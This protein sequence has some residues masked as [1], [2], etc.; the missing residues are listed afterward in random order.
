MVH[1]S[2]AFVPHRESAEAMK[3]GQGPFD[4]PPGDAEPAPV[5][6]APAGEDGHDALGLQSVAVRLRVVAPVALQRIG[7]AAWSAASPTDRGQ[8]G[9]ER[10]ELGNVV[11]VG[12][13]QLRDEWDAPRLS[14]DVVFGARLA[15]IGW[16][17]SSFFPPRNA[18][19]DALS[20]TAHRRSKRP[21]RRNS[22][23]SVSWRRCQ[24]PARC[25]RT[26]RRQQVLPDP[27]PISR[28]NICQGSPARSTKRIP[29]SAARSGTRGRPI[30]RP[31]RRGG[32]GSN[33][34]RRAQ[35]RSSIK[36]WDMPDRTK[37]P[38]PVQVPQ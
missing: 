6:R 9:D 28:G 10:V 24:T 4:Y 37:R 34:S 11:D 22:A 5:W 1:V 26:N 21:R 19:S 8:G 17:R 16:V 38:G 31:R 32:L 12:G 3:P 27:Q 30:R 13:R 23:R 7:F 36:G 25:Q 14:D 18:R 33:G 15:A 29:V 2:T 20:T 35:S